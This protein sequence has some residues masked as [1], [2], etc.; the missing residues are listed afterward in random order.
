[1]L[2]MAVTG[3]HVPEH[4]QHQQEERG[5]AEAVHRLARQTQKHRVKQMTT[6]VPRQMSVSAKS[7][8]LTVVPS[9]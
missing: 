4:D 2:F 9:R 7:L 5:E 1:M 3:Q 6:V 8:L